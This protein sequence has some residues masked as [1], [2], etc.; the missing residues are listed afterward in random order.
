[1]AEQGREFGVTTGRRRKTNW[2]NIDKLIKAINLTGTTDIIISKID[3]LETIKSFKLIH[4]KQVIAFLNINE[5]KEYLTEFINKS[6]PLLINIYYSDNPES[7]EGL[8]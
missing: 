2:L 5:M 7:V 1:M 3:I 8:I 4:N 6:C